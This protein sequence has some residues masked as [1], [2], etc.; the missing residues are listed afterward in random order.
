[1]GHPFVSRR[2]TA[3]ARPPQ[4]ESFDPFAAAAIVKL[5]QIYVQGYRPRRA[6]GLYSHQGCDL[7][8]VTVRG[9][10]LRS[11]GRRCS[12]HVRRPHRDAGDRS[13]PRII[14][15]TPSASP[16]AGPTSAR[17]ARVAGMLEQVPRFHDVMPAQADISANDGRDWRVFIMKAYGV[18][19]GEEPATLPTVAALL[20][21]AP[22]VVSAD[23]VV[24]GARQTHPRA[25]RPVPR[26]P[27]L[28]SDAVDAARRHTA[29]P[30]AS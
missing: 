27:A 17:S 26:H 19:G 28:S 16:T 6:A 3:Q 20:D 22:E 2:R 4:A 11:R 1:M 7:R 14:S 12:R 23:L 29:S 18:H 25:P 9:T 15:P 30:L 13:R 21:E 5:R 24:S 8:G 10:D